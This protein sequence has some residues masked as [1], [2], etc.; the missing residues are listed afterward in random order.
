MEFEILNFWSIIY[1]LF[2][3]LIGLIFGLLPGL[4]GV[5][6]LALLTPITYALS[7]NDALLLLIGA[8]GA[9]PFGGSVTSILLNTPGTSQNTATVLDGFPMTCQGKA[10]QALGAASTASAL[11]GIFGAIVLALIIP[12]GRSLVMA[13]SYPEYFM[14]AALGLSVISVV[15]EQSLLKGFI[16]GILGLLFAS[17][18][19]DPV[20]G[21]LRFS[22]EINYLWQGVKI[23][24]VLL[25]L[26]AI[27]ES[28]DLLQKGQPIA[29]QSASTKI[30]GIGEGIK[31]VF[32]H[33]GLFFRSSVMGTIIGIIPGVGGSVANVVVYGFAVQT[34]KEKGSFGKGDIRGVIAPEAANNAKEGGALLPTLIFGIPGGAEMAVLLGALMLHGIQPGPRMLLDHADIVYSIIFALLASSILASVIGLCLAPYAAKITVAPVKY[35]APVVFSLSLVGTYAVNAETGD[36]IV[37]LIFGVLGYFMKHYGYS[38]AALVVGLVLG[39]LFQSAYHQTIQAMGYAGFFNRPISIGL[40][41][42]IIA[43]IVWTVIRY[44]R[45]KHIMT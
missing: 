45:E 18:G 37:A 33:F 19:Y 16:S 34:A 11:G 38:R 42:L 31:S 15:S 39:D 35:I 13:F 1:L 24:P 12:I 3:I 6:C 20:T 7:P 4:G 17:F 9:V 8:A 2:G 40:F 14:L 25:G 32:K 41:I 43:L 10:G 5:Q 22:F 27:A 29:V 36:M 23:V 21:S 28:I 26:F 30:T 44:R